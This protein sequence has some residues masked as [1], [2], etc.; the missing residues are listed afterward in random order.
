MQNGN[1][2]IIAIMKRG[3]RL[4]VAVAGLVLTGTLMGAAQQEQL[5]PTDDTGLPEKIWKRGLAIAPVPLNLEGK[6]KRLVG[7]GSY[8]VNAQGAC[9]DCHTNPVFLPGG[10]PFMGQ[11]EQINTL[12]YLAG[13][14]AFGP[15]IRSANITPDAQ[16][17]PAGLTFEQFVE[18]MRTGRD[19]K[20]RHPQIS[21]LL[22]THPWP[23][24]AKM[25]DDD[26]RAIYE[27]LRAVPHAD[28]AP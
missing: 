1:L 13:G 27:Y 5:E 21:P 16:G 26:L 23:F 8:I 4:C 18:V 7:E 24:F 25:T 20:N 2:K 17:L 9:A 12:R 19:F 15:I 14:R 28:P 22:Q 11:P 10:N 6:S 3:M